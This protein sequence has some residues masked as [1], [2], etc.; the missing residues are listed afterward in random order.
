VLSCCSLISPSRQEMHCCQIKFKVL[1]SV[2]P[3]AV[4]CAESKAIPGSTRS[5]RPGKHGYTIGF[6]SYYLLFPVIPE[7]RPIGLNTILIHSPSKE[8]ATKKNHVLCSIYP[9]TT[10]ATP[11]C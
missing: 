10:P 11:N 5:A 7:P 8:G 6:R 9:V 2:Y 1:P 4:N 3:S